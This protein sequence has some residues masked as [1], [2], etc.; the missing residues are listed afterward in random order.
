MNKLLA[1][2]AAIGL[3][4]TP[5]L[6][7]APADNAPITDSEIS[8]RAM[9]C[10]KLAKKEYTPAQVVNGLQLD[11]QRKQRDFVIQCRMLFFGIEAATN[12]YNT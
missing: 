4:S 12:N 6:A 10:L 1:V 2:I 3:V 8:S 9:I 11:T 5:A 7:A